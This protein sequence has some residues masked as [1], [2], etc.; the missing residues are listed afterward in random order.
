MTRSLSNV[1]GVDDAPF[2]RTHRGEVPIVGTICTRTRLDGVVTSRVR[3]DGRN[4]T[5]RIASMLAGSPFG[6]HVQAIVLNG[7][8][9]AG[10]N[11]VDLAALHGQTGLPVVAIARKAPDLAAIE[12]A[13]R[14]RVPGG[15]RKWR[16]IEQ[17]GAMEPLDGVWVQRAGASRAEVSTMLRATRAQGLLPE[18]LRLAHLIAGAI[19]RGTSKGGA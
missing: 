14:T 8:A 6:A 4:A 2:E 9:V 11:V 12:R 5:E 16:L 18:P 1:M 13:L 3:R 7:I 15:A 17:A 19:G 10:F